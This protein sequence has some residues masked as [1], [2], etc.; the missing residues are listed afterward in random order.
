[1]GQPGRD[2]NI[3]SRLYLQQITKRDFSGRGEEGA[4]CWLVLGRR[5]ESES[6]VFLNRV[7]NL[8]FVLKTY[9]ERA[10]RKEATLL[11]QEGIQKLFIVSS[12]LLPSGKETDRGGGLLNETSSDRHTCR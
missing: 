10:C 8:G 7:W 3:G 6:C 5:R 1:M 2:L 12:G 9:T 4:G 11:M